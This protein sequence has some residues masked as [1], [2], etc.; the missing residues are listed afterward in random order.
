MILFF[1]DPAI[2]IFAVQTDN[3]LPS[4]DISK[5]TWLFGNQ[6]LIEAESLPGPFVGPRATMISPWS[7]NAVEITQ[8][9]A[10]SGI[11]RMEEYLPIGEGEDY[12]PMLSQKFAEL[13]QTLFDIHIEPAPIQAIEDIAAFNEQEGLALSSEEIDYLNGVAQRIGRPLTDSEVFGFSQVNSEH[14][15]H[16]IFNGTFV[17]DGEEKETSLFKL[18]KKTSADTSQRNRFRIQGQRG[19][20]ERPDRHAVCSPAPRRAGY[21]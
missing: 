7:T 19:F 16:K 4:T 1:G 9:M 14:C 6:A 3:A 2:K 11:R 5:L 21:L 12:D 18:I 13:N 20:C 10:I 17:I 8:N 15:R